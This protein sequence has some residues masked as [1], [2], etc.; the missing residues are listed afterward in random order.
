[1]RVGNLVPGPNRVAR[2]PAV[3]M[4]VQVGRILD[5][6]AVLRRTPDRTRVGLFDRYERYI[7]AV[8]EPVEEWLDGRKACRVPEADLFSRMRDVFRMDLEAQYESGAP[9]AALAT[10]GM[11]RKRK[12]NCYSSTVL[13]ADVCARLDKGLEIVNVPGH[14]LIAGSRECF[15]TTRNPGDVPTFRRS[16]LRERYPSRGIHGVDRLLLEALRSTGATLF[17]RKDFAGA[18]SMLKGALRIDSDDPNV[19]KS[20]AGALAC[21]GRHME[22]EMVLDKVFTE[23]PK[24]VAMLSNAHYHALDSLVG[25]NPVHAQVST[26]ALDPD[27]SLALSKRAAVLCET[28]RYA[29]ALSLLGRALTIDPGFYAAW[30]NSGVVMDALGLKR[31]AREFYRRAKSL[32]R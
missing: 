7:S 26:V 21:A 12:F 2:Q 4:P 31:Q 32:Y 15:E 9:V 19:L 23:D 29:E 25:H 3:V 27:S 30:R 13:F 24:I 10:S 17:R 8:M 5:A 6:E 20:L 28:E 18:V 14:V 1:M 22:A 16:E 11:L